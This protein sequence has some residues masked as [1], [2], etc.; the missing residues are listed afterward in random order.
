MSGIN[1]P[2]SIAEAGE[3]KTRIAEVLGDFKILIDEYSMRK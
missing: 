2:G 3:N 1:P